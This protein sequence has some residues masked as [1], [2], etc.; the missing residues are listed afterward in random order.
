MILKYKKPYAEGE[1]DTET[2][3]LI[4]LPARPI[5]Y[6]RHPILCITEGKNS[7]NFQIGE[8]DFGSLEDENAMAKEIERRW[9]LVRDLEQKEPDDSIIISADKIKEIMQHPELIKEIMDQIIHEGAEM[10]EREYQKL[11][12]QV[13]KPC[14]DGFYGLIEKG[15]K[16]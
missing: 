1:F 9:N 14:G 8:L 15:E 16:Q 7:M 6:E 12:S 2:I 11:L 13:G 5:K 3:E 10:A 4:A